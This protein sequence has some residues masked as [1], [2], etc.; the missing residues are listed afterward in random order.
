MYIPTPSAIRA[1]R[2]QLFHLNSLTPEKLAKGAQTALVFYPATEPPATEALAAKCKYEPGASDE[3]FAVVL[4]DGKRIAFDLA[5]STIV[6]TD[7]AAPDMKPL[8]E[9]FIQ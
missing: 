1:R 3:Q 9:R 7:A 5:T 8:R 2:E 6:M 4:D